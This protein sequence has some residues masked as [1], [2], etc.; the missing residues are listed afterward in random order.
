LI[1][2]VV[3]EHKSRVVALHDPV[4]LVGYFSSRRTPD[5]ASDMS[6]AR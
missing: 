4:L 6:R 5:S 3:A 1:D 2:P